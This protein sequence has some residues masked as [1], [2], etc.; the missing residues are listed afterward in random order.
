MP[1]IAKRPFMAG[2]NGDVQ[3]RRQEPPKKIRRV[4]EPTCHMC[5]A[6]LQQSALLIVK[7]LVY[8]IRP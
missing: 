3:R 8:G 6:R 1:Q 4:G 5:A 7:T 2:H